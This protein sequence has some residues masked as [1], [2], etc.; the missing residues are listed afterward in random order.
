MIL[1]CAKPI[2]EVSAAV[3]AFFGTDH[4][5]YEVFVIL[6]DAEHRAELEDLSTSLILTNALPGRLL[7]LQRFERLESSTATAVRS[8]I[9]RIRTDVD[10]LADAI[11]RKRVELAMDCLQRIGAMGAL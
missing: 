4:F 5:V 8:R 2:A 11:A 1:D 9:L 7:L 10:P 6:D 3:K